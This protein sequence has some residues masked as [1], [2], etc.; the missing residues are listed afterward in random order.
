M[1][2]KEG[3]GKRDREREGGGEKRGEKER[4]IAQGKMKIE[5]EGKE[6]KGRQRM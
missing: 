6:G 4:R 5:N 3:S 1:K 2:R